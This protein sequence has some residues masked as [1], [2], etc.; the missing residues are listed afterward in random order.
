MSNNF[1]NKFLTCMDKTIINSIINDQN[2]LNLLFRNKYEKLELKD[3]LN[4]EEEGF[5]SLINKRIY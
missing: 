4:E 1:R 2:F 5:E 3:N